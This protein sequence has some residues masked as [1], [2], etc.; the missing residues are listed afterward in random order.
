VCLCVD[1][2]VYKSYSQ[3]LFAEFKEMMASEFEMLDLG[4]L[5]HFLGWRLRK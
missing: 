4:N 5:Q 3:T 2:I 1:D